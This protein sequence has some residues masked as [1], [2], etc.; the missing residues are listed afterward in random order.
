MSVNLNRKNRMNRA[1]I[2]ILVGE[3]CTSEEL[4]RAIDKARG[5][6]EPEAAP[7][8]VSLSDLLNRIKAARAAANMRAAEVPPREPCGCNDG[9]LPAR[10]APPKASVSATAGEIT[11]D[12]LT[13]GHSLVGK[14]GYRLTRLVQRA[15]LAEHSYRAGVRH[16]GVTSWAVGTDPMDAVY[17]AVSLARQ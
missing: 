17:N 7:P 12:L 2:V 4:S 11:G 16:N 6:G 14:T 10:K 13:Q 5:Q 9:A 3:N 8:F 1:P 15:E